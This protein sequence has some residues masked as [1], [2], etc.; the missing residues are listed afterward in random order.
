MKTSIKR[1]AAGMRTSYKRS[2]FGEMKRGQF[3]AFARAALIQ[4]TATATVSTSGRVTIPKAV[5][6]ALRLKAGDTLNFTL[7]SDGAVILR[8]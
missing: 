4:N 6:D 5:R 2:D 8:A 7:R 1:D 3:V